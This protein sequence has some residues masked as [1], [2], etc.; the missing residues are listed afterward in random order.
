M[1]A[2]HSA[3]GFATG[4]SRP[5]RI[6]RAL[7]AACALSIVC[8]AF[9]QEPITAV[10][11]K[12]EL[13]FFYRSNFN[14]YACDELRHRVA[15]LLVAAGARDDIQVRVSDCDLAVMPEPN[16]GPQRNRWGRSNPED[17]FR[18]SR[19]ELGQTSHVRI[20]LMIPVEATPEVLAEIEKDRARQD[21]V[22]RVTGNPNAAFSG[23]VVF[24]ATR[25]EVKL[26]HRTH[27]LEPE[28]C[29]L[30]EQMTSRVYRELGVRVV[31]RNYHCDPGEL[32]RIPPQLTLE[33]LLPVGAAQPKLEP[34]D[35]PDPV[36]PAEGENTPSEEPASEAPPPQ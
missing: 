26:N 36:E 28:D 12:R 2:I 19:S 29:E 21:L 23:P 30:L 6:A 20:R 15:V 24:P 13:D 10:Y 7:L 34:K 22:S 17:R 18:G 4:K 33:A 5:A 3:S 11:K 14:E 1:T 9:A 8:Q 25:Q 16:V 31:R 27:R 35:D 32:S